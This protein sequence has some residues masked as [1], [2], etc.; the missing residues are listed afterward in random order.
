MERLGV[1][2]HP[3]NALTARTVQ[4]ARAGNRVRRMAD[5]GGLHLVVAPSGAKNWILR[6]V[7]RGRRCDIGLG[8]VT[9]YVFN[10][11][12]EPLGRAPTL[13]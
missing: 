3:H 10:G 9:L 8:S 12:I 2:R 6:T 13:S 7:V 5:G 11:Q 1:N 4:A